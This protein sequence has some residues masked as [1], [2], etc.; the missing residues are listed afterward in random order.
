MEERLQKLLSAR[1]I[2]SRRMAEEWIA[3]GRV[4]VNGVTASLGAKADPDRDEILLDGKPLPG[5]AEMVYLM[6]NKPRGFVTTLQDE[7]GRR[8]VADLVSDC[9][10]RVYPVGRLD[11]YSEGL[12]ILTNDGE[13]AYRLAHPKYQVKK[14]YH[15]WLSHWTRDALTTLRGPIPL[16]EG[17][18][19]AV[20]VKVLSQKADTAM[21]EMTITQGRNRQIRRMCQAA[22]VTVT[23]LRRVSEGEL[24]LGE[25]RTG[26]WRFLTD[27]E[28]EY[29]HNL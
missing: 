28:I 18:V 2:T 19:Q 29:L 23:R 22:G 1:G 21:V 20:R 13:A 4:Q 10:T 7:R 8:T 25:L 5:A 27:Q 24:R 16:E 3:A 11:Q 6:L 12:L 9:G 14:T 15:V 17:T 26:Q